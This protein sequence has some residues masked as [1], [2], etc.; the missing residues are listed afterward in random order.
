M[1]MNN[2]IIGFYTNIGQFVVGLVINDTETAFT[3]DKPLLILIREDLQS[4]APRVTAKPLELI[5]EMPDVSIRQTGIM[6]DSNAPIPFTFKKDEV[7]SFVELSDAFVQQYIQMANQSSNTAI[8]ETAVAQNTQT[9]DT[10]N[11]F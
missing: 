5:N 1:K 8:A 6:K 9:P 11:L 10:V 3:V 4:K 2:Q 7:K